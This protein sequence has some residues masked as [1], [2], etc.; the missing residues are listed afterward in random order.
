M[1]QAPEAID[2]FEILRTLKD[3]HL[4]YAGLKDREKKK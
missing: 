1:C 2:G 4:Y 3:G